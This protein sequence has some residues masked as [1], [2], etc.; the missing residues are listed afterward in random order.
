MTASNPILSILVATDLT[1]GSTDP[2]RAAA[3]LAIVTGARLHV[4]HGHAEP[5]MLSGGR[6]LLTVQ[7]QVHA[8]RAALID[9]IQGLAHPRTEIA[10]ARI[11]IGSPAQIILEEAR[12]VGADLIVL[13]AHRHRGVA[14]RLIGSTAEHV[15]RRS[16]TPC[17]VVNGPLT[18]PLTRVLTPTALTGDAI[19]VTTTAL[20]WA[21]HL[22]QTEG[23]E[24][25]LAHAVD[26]VAGLDGPLE[27]RPD[28]QYEL[29]TTASEATR[30]ARCYLPIRKQLIQGGDPATE[31]ASLASTLDAELVVLG[32]QADPTLV[33]M[34]LGS[35]TSAV[36]RSVAL[37][38]LLV[39]PVRRP[40][41]TTR[42]PA[43]RPDILAES[44]AM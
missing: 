33:R 38:I 11:H 23:A 41:A 19:R 39:P 36:V 20:I 43:P 14:D 4:I 10:S 29:E 8:K 28:L 24:M 5:S 3:D 21:D 22:C 30:R 12:N 1:A 2:L 16:S 32:T 15:L 40:K 13:G 26:P 9:M 25:T 18:L 35:V 17:L 7:R 37:P 44:M 27:L 42:T 34:L 6:D 31:I